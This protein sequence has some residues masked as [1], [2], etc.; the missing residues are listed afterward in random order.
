MQ[1]II[2]YTS[3]SLEKTRLGEILERIKQYYKRFLK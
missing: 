3:T 1:L 2:F